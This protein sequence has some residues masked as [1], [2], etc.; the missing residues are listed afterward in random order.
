MGR[1]RKLSMGMSNSMSD[2]G[3][4]ST[5]SYQSATS[6]TIRPAAVYK[7]PKDDRR[8]RKITDTSSWTP[9]KGKC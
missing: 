3:S 2:L 7:A 4:Q 9:G 8:Q 6:K 1:S 5:S